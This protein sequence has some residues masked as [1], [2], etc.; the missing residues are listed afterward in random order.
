MAIG[1]AALLLGLLLDGLK[2]SIHS[3]FSGYRL[4]LVFGFAASDAEVEPHPHRDPYLWILRRARCRQQ[5]AQEHLKNAKNANGAQLLRLRFG[6]VPSARIRPTRLG[7]RSQTF[8]PHLEMVYGLTRS[9][10]GRMQALLSSE[11]RDGLRET[12]TPLRL[13]LNLSLLAFFTGLALSVWGIVVAARATTT[14]RESLTIPAAAV[15]GALFS[16]VSYCW[17]VGHA[18]SL[19][20]A[21]VALIDVTVADLYKTLGVRRPLANEQIAVGTAIT[22]LLEYG[23][24][25]DDVFRINDDKTAS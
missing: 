10:W 13:F 21:T 22:A 1:G 12:E 25:I 3:A 20:Q 14:V 2:Q 17:S 18:E 4:A 7:N 5:K 19:A 15:G 9:A 24:P 23:I 16:W 8:E 11:Q 6:D